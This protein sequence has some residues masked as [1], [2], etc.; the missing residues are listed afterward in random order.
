MNNTFSKDY[1]MQ[2]IPVDHTPIIK[3]LSSSL[4][5]EAVS[6]HM[7]GHTN[8]KAFSKWLHENALSIDTTEL[9]STDNL[10]SPGAA[11][12]EAYVLAAKAF[13]AKETFFITT[14]STTAIYAAFLSVAAPGDEVIVFRNVHKSVLNACA[15]FD[16]IPVF[17][18]EA[19]IQTVIENHPGA[20][21]VFV[22]RPDYYGRC[23]DINALSN[24][25]HN[26]NKILIVD[27]AH[28]THF[29][30]C[31]SALPVPAITNGADIV[32]QSAH[33]T[34]PAL[35][36]ASFLHLSCEG[37]GL[38]RVDPV[39][40]KEALSMISTSS[41]SFL[42]AATLDFARAFLEEYGDSK[43]KQ[44]LLNLT[45]FYSLLDPKWFPCFE[46]PDEK[47]SRVT[48]DPFRMVIT[49]RNMPFTAKDLYKE[50]FD[51]GIMVEFY[52]LFRLVLICKFE[53]TRED[54]ILLS[55]V[56]NHFL[57]ESEAAV[58]ESL[59]SRI[60]QLALLDAQLLNA[61]NCFPERVFLPHAAMS[62]KGRTESIPLREAAHRVLF[63]AIIPYPPGI[64]LVW[65]G[66]VISAEAVFLIEGLLGNGYSIYGI[67]ASFDEK[68]G[69]LLPHVC[70]IVDGFC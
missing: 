33:K 21:A 55:R 63:S 31:P 7:P 60:R 62:Q 2:D 26:A 17:T 69:R 44:L 57:H 8:G 36:Q 53:N 22:T 50:F 43:A 5:K 16:F 23:M 10:Q 37:V 19:T 42:I 34:V 39:R 58:D 14:G 70:C 15:M 45:Y 64:P 65:P 13:G 61:M 30:F 18:T 6:F 49:V 27:E 41:P 47:N 9:E 59:E 32:V 54:F 56:M 48:Y 12:K 68:A 67:E 1:S 35:T 38:G 29:A 28:G 52:D 24:L 46:H 51:L 3:M 20:V 4:Q 25:V 40:V 11:V 66:E